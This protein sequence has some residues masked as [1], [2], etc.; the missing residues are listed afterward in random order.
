MVPA[1]GVPGHYSRADEL[2]QDLFRGNWEILGSGGEL[3]AKA[4]L[5]HR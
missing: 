1:C 5:L 3:R 2:A 4:Y